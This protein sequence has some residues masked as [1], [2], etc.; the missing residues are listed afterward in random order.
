[1]AVIARVAFKLAMLLEWVAT[2]DIPA[3]KFCRPPNL[4]QIDHS[5]R[6]AAK[7]SPAVVARGNQA[8]LR[9]DERATL[10]HIHRPVLVVS[11]ANDPA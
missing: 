4:G 10:P 3:D 6:L 11:G 7:A 8:M 9:F 2:P 5:S 1:M